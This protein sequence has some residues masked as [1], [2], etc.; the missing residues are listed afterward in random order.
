MRIIFYVL[1]L[2]SF[3]AGQDLPDGEG[4]Q[5]FMSKCGQCHGLDY[6]TANRH[7]RGQWGGIITQMVDMGAV[8]TDEDRTVII[9]YVTKNFGRISVNTAR[10]EEI[11][12]FLG[13][14]TKDAKAIVSY[15]SEHGPFQSLDEL[16]KVPDIDLKILEEKKSLILF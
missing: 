12:S 11:E 6:A 8:L 15:R 3:A 14:S 13:L 10:A 2:S 5:I 9:D 16:K 7:T 4:K 1:I